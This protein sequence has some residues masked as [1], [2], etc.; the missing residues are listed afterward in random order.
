M[1]DQ[2]FVTKLA[3][4]Q[5]F[6]D[7][8][9]RIAATQLLAKPMTVIQVKT[10]IKDGYSALQ[11]AIDQKT[12]KT[13]AKP[14]INHLKK[15][16]LTLS[17]RF[18]REVRLDDVSTYN[19]GDQINLSDILKPGDQI[20]AT[21]LSKGRG[22]AGAMKRHGFH[23]GPKTHGQSDRPR[24]PG[25]IGMRTTPGRVWKGKKMAGHYGQD[26]KAIRNLRVI[27]FDDK[28]NTLLISGTISGSR[29]T[30]INLLKTKAAKK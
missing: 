2:F 10:T 24:S 11:L 18:I 15:A 19:L 14:L 20:K 22:F 9:N 4:S 3:T 12:T 27:S 21:G 6:D 23:G 8:G 16:K 26:S 29:Q 5:I 7:Q 17:P 13:I 28:T 25:S 1:I 30:L